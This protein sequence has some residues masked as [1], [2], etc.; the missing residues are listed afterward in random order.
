MRRLR[1]PAVQDRDDPGRV[2][3]RETRSRR[4]GEDLSAAGQIGTVA[5][6]RV[7]ARP[8]RI[9]RRLCLS[10]RALVESRVCLGARSACGQRRRCIGRTLRPGSAPAL[11]AVDPRS[12]HVTQSTEG[13][14]V[15]RRSS[16][17][18]SS[19]EG[20]KLAGRLDLKKLGMAG[21]SF[22]AWTTLAIAGQKS[23]LPIARQPLAGRSRASRRPIEMSSPGAGRPGRRRRQGL[24]RSHDPDVPHDGHTR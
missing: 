22:G 20:Q 10:R 18:G 1:T 2:E 14:F 3:G 12:V 6:D 9:A 23:D 5:R 19:A 11:E 17:S 7:F 21:H 16:W 8:R 24:L 13:Y 4:S 15:R